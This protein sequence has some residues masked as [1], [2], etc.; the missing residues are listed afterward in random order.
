LNNSY[1]FRTAFITGG[2]KRIGKALSTR[3]ANQGWSL[4]IHYYD[5]KNEAEELTESINKNGGMAIS[6]KANLNNSE[7]T[8][9]AFEFAYKKI[10]PIDLLINNASIFKS[11]E[12]HEVS[13]ISWENNININ[14]K[15][16]FILSQELARKLPKNTHAN[17]I[18]IIDQ[19]VYNIKSDFFTY[20]LSKSGLL[21]LTRMMAISLAPWIRV[22]GIGP[23]PTL[24]NNEQTNENFLKQAK[25][26]L[27]AKQVNPDQIANAMCYLI[28]AHSVTGQMIAVDS[29]EHLV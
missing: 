27:L 8:R 11:E 20:T 1:K 4:A 15:S 26:T 14:L 18:N 25:N 3:L 7:E 2:A 17:I 12:W 21:T 22:N 28:D 16:P 19:R 23:G 29:G 24:P 5:S 9:K 6:I 13:D 10:G